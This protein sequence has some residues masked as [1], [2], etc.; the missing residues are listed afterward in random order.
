M[1]V[2]LSEAANPQ[3]TVEDTCTF[4]PVDGPQF[5]IADGEV[6]VTAQ[7]RL[8]DHDMERTIHRLE[9][10]LAVFHL[11]RGEHVVAIVVDVAAGLP[12]V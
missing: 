6:S 4:V 9:L 3:Q 11:H 8:V 2:I 5:A 10:V 1:R 7:M 12:E